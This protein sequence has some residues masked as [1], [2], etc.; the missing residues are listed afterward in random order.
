MILQETKDA[1]EKDIQSIPVIASNLQHIATTNI[2]NGNLLTD[3][4]RVLT[5]YA[6]RLEEKDKEI[7]GFKEAVQNLHDGYDIC[8]SDYQKV[9]A[10]YKA[11]LESKDH[12]IEQLTKDIKDQGEYLKEMINVNVL[13]D[14]F[15]SGEEW[16][17][18]HKVK[19]G[20]QFTD[21]FLRVFNVEKEDRDRELARLKEIAERMA[22]ALDDSNSMDSDGTL[23]AQAL[24]AYAEW[25]K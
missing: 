19:E 25:C 2:I 16:R 24:T 23:N 12:E 9:I 11:Q 18:N 7:E 8:K 3:F 14:A 10:K 21:Y 6:E 15:N 4:R 13:N 1:I 22:I 17:K 20:E 5:K